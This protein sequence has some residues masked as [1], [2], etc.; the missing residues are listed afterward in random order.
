MH[1]IFWNEIEDCC[2]ECCSIVSIFLEVLGLSLY[3]KKYVTERKNSYWERIRLNL[4]M[5]C[6]EEK[7]KK[8]EKYLKEDEEGTDRKHDLFFAGWRPEPLNAITPLFFFDID[9]VTCQYRTQLLSYNLIS[10]ANW[11]RELPFETCY[12]FLQ[13]GNKPSLIEFT[14][15]FQ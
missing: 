6:V 13:T 8:S 5:S 1:T 2:N 11:Y 4:G 15:T 7:E 3:V 9:N 12:V 14:I 10:R